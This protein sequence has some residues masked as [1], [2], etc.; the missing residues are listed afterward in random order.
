MQDDRHFWVLDKRVLEYVRFNEFQWWELGAIAVV[1][2]ALGGY[3]LLALYLDRRAR[4]RSR[5]R[6][7]RARLE[8]WLEDWQ[9][10]PEELEALQGMAGGSRPE[11]L[12]AL[13]AD[14]VRFERAVHQ[15]VQAEEPLRFI[16]RVREALGYRSSNLHVPIASTRQLVAGDHFRFTVWEEGRPQHHYGFVTAVS[17]AGVAVELTEAGF[18][19]V[20]QRA[21][22]VE[23]FYL[24]GSDVEVRFP[25]RIRSRDTDRHR[26]LLAH[27]LVRG[28][29]QARSTRLP[30]L[31]PIHFRL[32]AQLGRMEQEPTAGMPREADE[33][34]PPEAG[35]A[36]AGKPMRGALLEMSEGGFSMVVLQPVAEGAYVEFELPLPRGRTLPIMGRV[37]DC[38]PFAGTR[39]LVRCEQRGLTSTQRNTLSQ[40]LRLE[41]QRRLKA[42]QAERRKRRREEDKGD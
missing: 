18:K 10:E 25:L 36:P 24:R 20:Q 33:L 3:A 34:A 30:M 41:Q 29:H 7:Q 8:A 15:A 4:A 5:R 11:H 37:L 19:A 42:M 6:K 35:P 17:A 40:A 32:H 27:E 9:L 31:R 21:G 12:Y 22:E 1:L 23:L 28:G 13:L 14:P 2:G 16:E 26:L 39:W 38:R